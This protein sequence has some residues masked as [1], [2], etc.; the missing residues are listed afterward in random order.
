MSTI[1]LD[2]VTEQRLTHIAA[3][4]SKAP[5]QVIRDLLAEYL[6]DLEDAAE[7]EEI[8]ARLERGEEQTITLEEL[9]AR[10]DAMDD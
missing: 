9:E 1:H 10:L 3:L 8:L 6:Q 4:Q 2:T 5:E 7:A